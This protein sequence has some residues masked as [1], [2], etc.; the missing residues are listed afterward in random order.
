M[1]MDAWQ[2]AVSLLDTGMVGVA[3][4]KVNAVVRAGTADR[5]RSR[6]PVRA[7]PQASGSGVQDVSMVTV[8]V[9][10]RIGPRTA[11]VSWSD[12]RLGSYG[13]QVWRAA[14][15]RRK[16]RCALSG[17]PVRKGDAIYRPRRSDPPP[18]NEDAMILAVF[19]DEIV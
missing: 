1:P 8:S 13:D 15:A 18:I 10:D 14:L 19:L 6:A 2:W 17:Q 12:S 5:K 11:V 16:G 9:I 7:L 3:V 4:A